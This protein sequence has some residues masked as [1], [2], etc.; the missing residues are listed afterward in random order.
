MAGSVELGVLGG[1]K[2]H[3][4]Y[5]L[6]PDIHG[7]FYWNVAVYLYYLAV[8]FNSAFAYSFGLYTG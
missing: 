5:N 7:Y 1:E 8:R 6:V 2:V 4:A 3:V